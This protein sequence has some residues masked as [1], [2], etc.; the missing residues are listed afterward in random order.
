M[1]TLLSFVLRCWFLASLLVM[2]QIAH[3]AQTFGVVTVNGGASVTVLPGSSVSVVVNVT[4]SG[5]TR[6][7]ATSWQIGTGTVTCVDHANHDANGSYSEAFSITAPAAEATYN[8]NLVASSTSSCGGTMTAFSLAN[9]I[10][11]SQPPTVSSINRVTASPTAASSV[12]WT[13][14]FS[15]SVTGVSA[16][17]FALVQAGGLSGATIASVTGGPAVYTVTASTGTGSGTLGLNLT[18]DDSIVDLS[19][20]PLG[21]V[22]AGNGSSTGQ[23]Y[24]VLAPAVTSI[25]RASTNPR[26][27]NSAV[28]WNVVFNTS[29]TGVDAADFA[30]TQAGGATG[31]SITSVAGSGANWTVTANTGTS[32]TGSLGLNLID[33]DSII[34]PVNTPLGGSGAGNGNFTGQVY[35]L[36]PPVPTLAKT[37]SASSAVVGDVVTFTIT[38]SNPYGVA[39]AN[40]VL[41]D[42]LPAGMAYSTHV[43]T[44]GAVAVAG[45]NVSW[46]IPSLPAGGSAQLTLAV[47]LTAQGSLTNTV[48]S[49]GAVS[50]S[51][52]ILV[53]ANAI[54]H[55]RMDEP[56]NS[57]TGVVGE[58]VD[59]GGTALHGRRL[60]TSTPTTTNTVLPAS[61]I[62]SQ[63]TSVIGGFCN[64][65]RFDGTA[66]VAV[67]DSPLFD[68]T[69][70]LS[71][72]AWIYPT[73]YPI[74]DLYS[75]LSND[76]NYEFHLNT[77]GKL[78]WW[79]NAATLTSSAT[80]PLNQWTHIA[81]TFSS[82]AGAGRQRIYINGV[83]DT[84]TNS[85]TGTLAA[86]ACPFYIGGDIA[87]GAACSLIPGR[88]FR[89]MIDEVK[90]YNFELGSAEVQA[91]MNLG[92]SCSGTFDHLQIEHDGVASIC[93]PETVTVKACFD[94]ACST[95]YTGNVTAHLSPA[96]W[97]GGDTFS[98]SGG[99][100]SRQL[101]YGTAGNVTLG[102]VSVSPGPA[103]STRCFKGATETCTMNFAASSCSF[104][105][106]EPA[107]G[108]QTRLF[109]KL[110]NVPFNVDV[111]ALLSPTTVNTGY[112]GTVAV[113]L[114]DAS[115]SAC[116][117]GAGLNTATN[118]TYVAANSGRKTVAFNYPK[119][120]RNVR[121]RATAGSSAPACS[122][123]SFTVRP[124]GFSAIY[125]SANADNAGVAAGAAPTVKAGSAF[126]LGADTGVV[127]YDGNPA[128]NPALLE[129]TNV[130]TGGRATPGTGVL[131]GSTPGNL[132]FSTAA[133]AV[134]GNA[135][136]G[137]FTYD[138]AGYFRFKINGVYD[139]T[140]PTDSGDKMG[141]DC[142]LS[143]FSNAVNASGK[144]GCNF[145]NASVSNHFGRFIPDHFDTAVTQACVAG[146]FTYSG[147]PFPLR[148][149]ARN[150]VGGATQNYSGAFAKAVTLSARDAG[151][152][153]ANPGPGLLAPAVVPAAD[154]SAGIANSTPAYTFTNLQTAQTGVRVRA[155][156]AEVSS[157]RVPAALTVEGVATILG[158][159]ARLGNAY[160]SELLDLPV[161]FRTESWNGNG[162]VL[163]T[164]DTCTGDIALGAA[165]AVSVALAPSVAGLTCVKDSGS[166][167]LSGA[168][169][170]VVT[171]GARRY[172]EGATPG[173]GFAGDFN[174]WLQ[175]P[176]A[177]NFGTAVMTATVPAWLGVIPPAIAGFGRYKTPLI[178]RRENY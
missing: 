83:A 125:S 146:N 104:D 76:V 116:P 161:S 167:G 82:T 58:V 11:V 5:G 117:T 88:N 12:Q 41:S 128:A 10:V 75:I 127:G 165:N 172:R 94:A 17:K 3:A 95:L 114:V 8:L 22:G 46:T 173:V 33:N 84:N 122:T 108:P 154:F 142:V 92:R 123:D 176:G 156:E 147:Q 139:D 159:R 144:Y 78:Y 49:P 102:T 77:S 32:S 111:L 107:A 126:T 150:L 148:I 91:D 42:A 149:T 166:P 18:D 115:T 134:S 28:S 157:L 37:A 67:A 138:E 51:A 143:S 119:A 50:A 14:T 47:S 68:Y 36:S 141:G 16:A 110:A 44:L 53:L 124:Q 59:S 31:S 39:L 61:T 13:V 73:A 137:G 85:W 65:G 175:A 113:D 21:G 24:S 80:I 1:S 109:T 98:F 23:V 170:V 136:S 171:V 164:L 74:S 112:A 69:T 163:N 38:A 178:Y 9:S 158:G 86:N 96:G 131:D 55:F 2:G 118:I 56:V 66:V 25:N 40:V 79:W 30:L 52:S 100:A 162:W 27:A 15:E 35:T 29:V 135:A 121:V 26:T 62:A 54:T 174:L 34:R 106:V 105:A 152:T 93:Q 45:Q 155:S 151:D 60:T 103:N 130:P 48:T 101:S 120:A 145:G 99:I 7:R 43:V 168:G 70:Q 160:G 72:S 177:G 90:L 57:W 140:F 89:G 132:S 63:F 20:N 133:T 6:W 71:A 19:G 4:T 129:W 169:C 153:A 64:A 81:I 97:V 87:T